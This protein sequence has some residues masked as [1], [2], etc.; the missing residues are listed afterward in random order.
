[1]LLFF[2]D[3]FENLS[4]QSRS[5]RRTFPSIGII[6]AKRS[7]TEEQPLAI[8]ISVCAVACFNNSFHV[9]VMTA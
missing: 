5:R 4:Y 2:I 7:N 9:N 6:L 3:K 8:F 1:M